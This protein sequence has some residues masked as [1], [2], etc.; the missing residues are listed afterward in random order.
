[1][2]NTTISSDDSLL[3]RFRSDDSI[4]NKGFTL[5]YTA[6]EIYDNELIEEKSIE[7]EA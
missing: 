6:I 1:M 2:P 4:H 5:T 7:R 3:I